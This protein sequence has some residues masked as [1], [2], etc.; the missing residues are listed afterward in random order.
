[1]MSVVRGRDGVIG[2]E[3]ADH[4]LDSGAAAQFAFDD[5]EHGALLAGDEDAAWILRIVS[6][7]PLTWGVSHQV[8]LFSCA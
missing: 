3:V 2:L 4:G 8:V 6:T 7:V 5:A 1:M